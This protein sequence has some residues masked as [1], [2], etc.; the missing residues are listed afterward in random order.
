MIRQTIMSV[1]L[2]CCGVVNASS[3]QNLLNLMKLSPFERAVTLTKYYEQWHTRKD[4]PYIG[5]G[6]RIMPGERLRYP[7]TEHQA[8]S[9][10]RSDLRKNCALFRQYGSDSLLLGCISYNCGCASL[11]GSKTKPRSEVLKKLDSGDRN[12][13][14][15]ILDF[16]HYKGK[17]HPYIQRRRWMEYLLLFDL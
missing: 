10:L 6:H 12:I 13:L 9:I 2:F 15:D 5:Y 17:R 8:D 1:I 16:C 14:S 11:L 7:I 3:Q 4:Y